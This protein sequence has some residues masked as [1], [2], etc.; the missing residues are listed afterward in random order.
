[1]VRFTR[2]CCKEQYKINMP[3]YLDKIRVVVEQKAMNYHLYGQ[4]TLPPA[5][6]KSSSPVRLLIWNK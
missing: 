2:E 3:E 5:Q 4:N 1:M 6:P